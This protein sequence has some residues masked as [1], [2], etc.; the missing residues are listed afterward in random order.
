[1]K[2]VDL[3]IIGILNVLYE[4]LNNDMMMIKSSKL[5]N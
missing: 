2:H 4:D 1:M 5:I 3:N